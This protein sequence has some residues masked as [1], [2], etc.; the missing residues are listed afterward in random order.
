MKIYTKKGDAGETSVLSGQKVSKNDSIIHFIGTL[1]ELNSHLGLIKSMLSHID[2]WQFDSISSCHFIEKIQKRLMKVMSHVSI[3]PFVKPAADS[4]ADANNEKYFLTDADVKI[5]EKEIDRL[6]INIPEQRE[7]I[8][9]GK[10]IIE[11]QIHIARTVARRAERL[12][13]AM[14]EAHPQTEFTLCPRNC[15]YLNR[16]SDY[17]FILS[18]QESLINVDFINQIT[19]V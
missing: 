16:L 9:P 10:N 17:L 3:M 6:V 5:L 11:A 4:S 8:I 1:E 19:G 18:Q 12:Y 15:A 14:K 7:L 13:F 2:T